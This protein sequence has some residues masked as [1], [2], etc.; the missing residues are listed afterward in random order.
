L[1]KNAKL[2]E[3]QGFKDQGS[4]VAMICIGYKEQGARVERLFMGYKEKVQKLPGY[5]QYRLQ[6]T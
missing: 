6:R 3:L 5:V 4:R 1:S 2:G